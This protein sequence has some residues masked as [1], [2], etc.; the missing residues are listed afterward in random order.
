VVARKPS[1]IGRL[2]ARLVLCTVLSI[3]AVGVFW[4]YSEYRNY[5]RLAEDGRQ[6]Y[7][8]QQRNFL[9]D[10]VKDTTGTIEYNRLQTEERLKGALR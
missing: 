5:A 9:R 6:N 3:L 2:S 7:M 10:L 8:D 1:L 4:A